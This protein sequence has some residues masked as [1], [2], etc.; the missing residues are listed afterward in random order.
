MPCS[1]GSAQPGAGS[2]GQRHRRRVP[3]RGLLVHRRDEIAV[4]SAENHVTTGHRVGAA[5]SGTRVDRDGHRRIDR[6]Q[7]SGGVLRSGVPASARPARTLMRFPN[8][9]AGSERCTSG[10]G[11]KQRPARAACAPG[12]T[13]S[14]RP[15]RAPS[16]PH[17]CRRARRTGRGP[18]ATYR[19]DRQA[20]V[21]EIRHTL[22]AAALCRTGVPYGI[23]TRVANVKGWSPGP[24]D[25]RDG[26]RFAPGRQALPAGWGGRAVP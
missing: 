21:D 1:D 22:C 6:D 10:C 18:L 7:S 26:A 24:L 13:G 16:L 4:R 25:E 11:K 9:R 17:A 20:G 8:A 19:I 3:R 2:G 23:R 14:V 12:G 15:R 5:A